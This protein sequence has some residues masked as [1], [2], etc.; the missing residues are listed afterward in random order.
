MYN[1]FDNDN[2]NIH[3][4]PQIKKWNIGSTTYKPIMC[5]FMSPP[6]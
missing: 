5:L 4:T 3:E 6:R 2:A 1:L